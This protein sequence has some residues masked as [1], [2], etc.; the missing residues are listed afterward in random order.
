[1]KL[2]AI[3]SLAIGLLE[4]FLFANLL[5]AQ[6]Y[7]AAV[8]IDLANV[9]MNTLAIR[10]EYALSNTVMLR[11]SL[12]ARYQQAHLGNT[13]SLILPEYKNEKNTG[14]GL[15]AGITLADH[16]ASS[17]PYFGI[18]SALIYYN[19]IF[20]NKQDEL[21]NS[22]GFTGG[23]AIALGYNLPIWERISL[24]FS[25]K[26]GYTFP[27]A[28]SRKSYFLPAGGYSLN[29]ISEGFANKSLYFMPS[30]IIRYNL[31]PMKKAHNYSPPEP[32]IENTLE[33][34]VSARKI[35]RSRG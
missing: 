20:K 6:P 11:A 10:G 29:G 2:F 30:F 28:D 27:L 9:I 17:Y 31:F 34:E 14:M 7:R 5:S 21:Q 19:D 33:E 16:Y 25:A 26:L 23:F 32:Q 13:R 3:R 12:G 8:G 15:C 4:I 22:K 1:M 18:N 35:G 24:D